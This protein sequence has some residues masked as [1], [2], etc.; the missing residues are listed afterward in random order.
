MT[1]TAFGQCFLILLALLACYGA[2]GLVAALFI[3]AVCHGPS[4]VNISAGTQ[5]YGL[6]PYNVSAAMLALW[7]GWLVLRGQL[8]WPDW[9]PTARRVLYAW[10]LFF[11]IT[12]LGALLLP[13]LFAGLD[14][15]GTDHKPGV[16]QFSLFNV[17]QLTNLCINSLMLVGIT[18]LAHRLELR[19]WLLGGFAGALAVAVLAGTMQ[20]L[21][22]RHLIGPLGSFWYSN[23]GYELGVWG[24]MEGVLRVSWPFSEPSYTSSW[25]AGFAGA[26]ATVLLLARPLSP[27]T[28][29]AI[30]GGGVLSL[31]G[32]ATSLGGSG[33]AGFAVFITALGLFWLSNLTQAA[34]RGVA[35][36]RLQ[37]LL[38][39]GLVSLLGLLL[40]TEASQRGQWL[41]A[42]RSLVLERALNY[43][44]GSLPRRRIDNQALASA[45][46]SFGLGVG[47][48][49]SRGSSLITTLLAT[50]GLPGTV[51]FA[52][53]LFRQLSALWQ[54]G[55][56]PLPLFIIGGTL[57]TLS[58][59]SA[60]IPDLNWPVL[61][62]FLIAGFVLLAR[63]KPASEKLN[64]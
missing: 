27:S 62:I 57:A 51:L 50:V 31:L 22:H 7:G 53:A 59:M 63:P 33:L 60:G 15:V 24:L 5:Q 9:T 13:W 44:D 2:R 55:R 45:W 37:V 46:G 49:S 26:C 6:T 28:S 30:L 52:F 40:F 25:F 1:L 36:Q 32:L 21:E 39:I 4:V 14:I 41:E 16:L 48:G 17:V 20:L 8:H 54:M 12:S 23:P 56:Q 64:S 3:S 18:C 10:G 35:L 47:L 34:T 19:P 58:A 38:G 43:A 61:W 11:G 42:G 29:L